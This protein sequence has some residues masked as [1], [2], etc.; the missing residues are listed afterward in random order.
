MIYRQL[1]ST[2]V[3]VSRLGFGAS[4]FGGAND[5]VYRVVGGLG[6]EDASALVGMA[7]DRGVNFFDT[8]DVYAEGEAET[9]LGHALGRR[10]QEVILATKV[11]H[12]LGPGVNDVGLSR[13]HIIDAIE[14]S[15]R[16]LNTD[17]IDLYQI[18]IFDPLT[19]FEETLRT[20][21]DLIGA[22]K[23]RYIGCSNLASWQIMKALGVAGLHGWEKFVSVQAYYSVVG[24]DIE[25][26]IVPLI[27]DQGLGLIT[28]SPLAGGFLTGKFTRNAKP[29]DG[30]RR[31]SFNFPPVELPSAYDAIDVLAE[32]ARR[33]EASLA[34]VALAWQLH[35]PFVTSIIL[36]AR[37]LVQLDDNL[38]SAELAL[39]DQDLEEI[40]AVS[41]LTPEYPAW[42]HAAA[43]KQ[44]KRIPS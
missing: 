34:Q 13:R 28:W 26:E 39:S 36:G 38:N 12:R 6:Q 10:R 17:Y 7:L 43:A 42:H 14:G 30:S 8:A 11:H 22:G 37:N 4:T 23:V 25:R 16:R 41:A 2:G 44:Q 33:H 21:D 3:F 15:L 1:G 20:L 24:R 5:P 40:E 32:I 35:K 19:R 27:E 9:L 31:L 29:D 18:H